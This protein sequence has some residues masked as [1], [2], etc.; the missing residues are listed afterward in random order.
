[1]HV[2]TFS[3]ACAHARFVSLLQTHTH[4][5]YPSLLSLA[6]SFSQDFPQALSLFRSLSLTLRLAHPFTL[7]LFFS[8]VASR[9]QVRLADVYFLYTYCVFPCAGVHCVLFLYIIHFLYVYYFCVKYI[10]CDHL[11]A[12]RF[13]VRPAIVSHPFGTSAHWR[14]KNRKRLQC[15]KRE[16]S[17]SST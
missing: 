1:M 12:S 9:F 8:D 2:A 7:C 4:A 15:S 5:L 13:Q 10:F 16:S 14:Q 6:L 17:C 11:T 3:C